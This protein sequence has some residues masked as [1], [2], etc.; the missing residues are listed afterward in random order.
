MASRCV[1]CVASKQVT[2]TLLRLSHHNQSTMPII[3][4]NLATLSTLVKLFSTQHTSWLSILLTILKRPLLLAFRLLASAS[5]TP[6]TSDIM[7]IEMEYQYIHVSYKSYSSVFQQTL[8][9]TLVYSTVHASGEGI[10]HCNVPSQCTC[11]NY[12]IAK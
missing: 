11:I 9:W 5:L 8:I 1:L 4:V 12:T 3:H 6:N 7:S 2:L 10:P